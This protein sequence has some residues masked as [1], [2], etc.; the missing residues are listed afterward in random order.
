LT[1]EILEKTKQYRNRF[2]ALERYLGMSITTKSH[3][4]GYHSMEQQE[5]LQGVGNLGEGFGERNY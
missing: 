2:L 3:L 5:D 1:P 4:A